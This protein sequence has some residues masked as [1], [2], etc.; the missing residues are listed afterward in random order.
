[1]NSILSFVFLVIFLQVE[2][3]YSPLTPGNKWTYKTDEGSFKV[4][5]SKEKF[6][7]NKTDYFQS[8]REYSDGTADIM[9]NRIGKENG[10][11]YY[12]DAQSFKESI[13]IPANPRLNYTWTST[14]SLWKYKVIEVGSTIKVPGQIFQNCIAIKAESLSTGGNGEVYVNYYAKGIGY[15]A[16]KINGTL[17]VYLQQ[18][19]ISTSS[20]S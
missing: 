5:V 2:N 12:L 10:I 19:K 15:V 11:V 16:T 9:Y 3:T 18:Y 4:E 8:I 17:S 13:E 7:H 20:K 1:M 14:D 6:I